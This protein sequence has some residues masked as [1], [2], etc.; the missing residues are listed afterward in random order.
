[1]KENSAYIYICISAAVEQAQQIY[2]YE[3]HRII[4]YWMYNTYIYK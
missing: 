4:G 2:I 3:C 1:M